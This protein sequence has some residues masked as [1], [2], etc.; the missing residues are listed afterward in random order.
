MSLLEIIAT[1]L[2]VACVLLAVKR[3]IWTYPIGIVGTVLFFFVFWNAQ[4]YSSAYLQVFFTFVQFYGW[5]FWLY[6][7]KGSKPRITTTPLYVL[8]A[9]VFV[10]V[11][12]AFSLS[13]VMTAVGA[14]MALLDSG[15]FVLSVIAQF[16]LDR[17][18]IETWI[19][20]AIVNVISIYVYRE[21][22]LIVT[23]LL[24]LGLLFNTAWGYYEWRKELTSYGKPF[25]RQTYSV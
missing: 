8:G 6:G 14:Q 16:M 18:K 1:V 17:K 19:M 11:L 21:Q 10:T 20:W 2:T 15:I 25:P 4:L 7:D 3:N 22:G 13:T 12:G 9:A 23:A 5:W 24:Y